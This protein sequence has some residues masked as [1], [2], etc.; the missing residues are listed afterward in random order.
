MA[1]KHTDGQ[2][3]FFA[4]RI[5][6]TR[7]ST[8]PHL[9]HV[10][11]RTV[12][13]TTCLDHRVGL[14]R[15]AHP[16]EVTVWR[17]IGVQYKLLLHISTLA[18]FRLFIVYCFYRVALGANTHTHSLTHVHA[19]THFSGNDNDQ[20]GPDVGAGVVEHPSFTYTVTWAHKAFCPTR[21][22]GWCP[23]SSIPPLPNP[24]AP[25]P[26]PPPVP[27][28]PSPPWGTVPLPTAPQ[29]AYYMSE[30]RALVHFNMATFIRDGDPGCS[31]DN[32][33]T[34]QP[35]AA[36]LSSDP[37]TFNPGEQVVP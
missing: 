32:W 10:T 28:P 16:K 36:G 20:G 9:W 6:T 12:N 14:G 15:V 23:P 27:P 17:S 29:L 4:T 2:N 24:P 21:R 33:N 37:A 13:N 11:D 5:A 31:A 19:R 7:G 35:Y 26:P 3:R 1:N 34:K 25:G 30:I 18:T 8:R 22:D